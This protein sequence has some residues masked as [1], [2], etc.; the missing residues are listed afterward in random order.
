MAPKKGA[1]KP[2][3][4]SPQKASAEI[5]RHE[6]WVMSQ[7]GE[8][9]LNRLVEVGILPDRVT[10]GWRPA[11]GEPYPMPHT[12]EVVVFEDY[13]WRGLGF[14]IHPFLKDLLEF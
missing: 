11:L 1:A 14:P 8:V 3:K 6:E 4:T 5:R 9:E 13:F 7:I 10:T 2:K 12:D